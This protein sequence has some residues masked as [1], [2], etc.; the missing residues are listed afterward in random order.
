MAKPVR[1]RSG[2]DSDKKRSGV[3]VD[4]GE[5]VDKLT[6]IVSCEHVH[7]APNPVL[8]SRTPHVM[9]N[10]PSGALFVAVE[11]GKVKILC[12]SCATIALQTT[13]D[14]AP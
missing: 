10:K 9:L 7:M 13:I 14:F 5:T 6:E 1:R 11:E 2:S 12:S 8:G 4:K 3:A